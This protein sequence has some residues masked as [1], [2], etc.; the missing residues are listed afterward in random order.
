M[1]N[2]LSIPSITSRGFSA[3]SNKSSV[4]PISLQEFVHEVAVFYR[5][6][7]RHKL[8]IVRALQARVRLRGYYQLLWRL[9]SVQL[10][11]ENE[12]HL[13]RRELNKL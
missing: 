13:K 7:P 8:S 12:A 6:S 3:N 9:P 11:S 4:H 10:Y 2:H 1:F 5:T